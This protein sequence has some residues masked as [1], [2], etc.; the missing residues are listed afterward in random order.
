MK[1]RNTILTTVLVALV[2][3][4]A[5]C[6][7]SFFTRPP[8]GD[9]TA[10]NFYTSEGDLRMATAALYNQVWFDWND[11]ASF[12][13]GDARAGNM[14][15]TDAGYQQ[16]TNFSVTQANNRL[17]EAWRSLYLAVNQS[18]LVLQ[19][20]ESK[21]SGDIPQEVVNEAKAEARFIRG[22]AYSYLAQL[23]GPVPIVV[24]TPRLIDQPDRRRNR[25]QDV[26]QFAINDFEYAAEHLPP[27]Q[28]EAGRVTE[29][30]A[31]GML[32][33]M[34]WTR[35]AFNGMNQEDLMQARSYAEDVIMNSGMSLRDNYGDL[36][37]LG[38]EETNNRE[39][40][41]FALQWTYQGNTWGTQNTTQSYFAPSSELTG[42]ADGWGGGTGV[43]AWLI[44]AFNA[45]NGGDD[46][47][48]E[49]FMMMNDYYPELLQAQGGYTYEAA[50]A[51][52]YTG[53]ATAI[54]KYVIGTPGDN[55]GRVAQQ[56]TGIDTYML[57]LAEIYLIYAQTFLGPD[58]SSMG[59]PTSNAQA[60]QYYNA[61][62]ERAGLQPRDSFDFMDIFMEKWKELAFEG[63]A[64][65]MLVR[66]HAFEPEAAKQFIRDQRRNRSVSYDADGNVTIEDDAASL[67]I[68]D[69]L[70]QL[71][72]PEVDVLQNDLLLEP[73]VEY[74]FSEQEAD[75][76]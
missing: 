38:E 8:E 50:G 63:Q 2:V 3:S 71:K 41:L 48:P 62:R 67:E 35:A 66:W 55:D 37:I 10:D 53:D 43:Q 75:S 7:D 21:V 60:L 12:T 24:N 25:R 9:L 42:F 65:F 52:S 51:N 19:N 39:E 56:R 61:V 11:K 33:R 14:W 72:Y 16:F 6:A 54:K 64:W 27:T 59:A 69:D 57:R 22:Y 76:E 32:A 1:Y 58:Q 40:S 29:W 36:F 15:S 18:N 13:I 45:P 34:Y 70:F 30:S 20:I 26:M 28:E 68:T 5:G 74:D 49:I 31:K 46:R 73:P 17:N 4:V 44:E 23:W 47:R